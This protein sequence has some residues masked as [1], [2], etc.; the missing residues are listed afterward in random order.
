MK[1]RV[2]VLFEPEGK[3]GCS[4]CQ[5]FLPVRNVALPNERIYFLYLVVSSSQMYMQ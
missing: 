2:A 1:T 3:E 4:E 5:Y